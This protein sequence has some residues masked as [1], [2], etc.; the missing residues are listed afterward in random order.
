MFLYHRFSDV[1]RGYKIV[2]MDSDGLNTRRIKASENL[3]G[4]SL[5]LLFGSKYHASSMMLI[6][7]MISLVVLVLTLRVFQIGM[8]VKFVR[9]EYA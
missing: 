4:L 7:E 1:F 8:K 2:T 5:C 6:M 3:I 9:S